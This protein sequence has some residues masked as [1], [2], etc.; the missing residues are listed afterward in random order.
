MSHL[1]S[2][3]HNRP[4]LGV[5]L[6]SQQTN[7]PETS[8]PQTLFPLARCFHPASKWVRTTQAVGLQIRF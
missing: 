2:Q 6:Q 5:P 7:S 4:E 1:H 8:F 3:R